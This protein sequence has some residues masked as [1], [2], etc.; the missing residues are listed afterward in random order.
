MEINNV[1]KDKYT[2]LKKKLLITAIAIIGVKFGGC[3]INLENA[4]IKIKLIGKIFPS[5]AFFK[6]LIIINILL[7]EKN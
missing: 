2:F 3:G 5:N 1:A 7:L 6:F 4:K